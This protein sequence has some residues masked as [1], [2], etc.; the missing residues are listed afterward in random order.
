[1]W[2]KHGEEVEVIELEKG[3]RD[4]V[5]EERGRRPDAYIGHVVD[6]RDTGQ[7]VEVFES[8]PCRR[9]KRS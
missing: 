7:E 9:C 8:I 2:Q 4:G 1:M 5:R 3:D 6:H